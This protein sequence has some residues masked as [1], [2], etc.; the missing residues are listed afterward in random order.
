MQKLYLFVFAFF[1]MK[2]WHIIIFI[3][4]FFFSHF[5]SCSSSYMMLVWVEKKVI[6]RIK[7]ISF[8]IQNYFLNNREKVFFLKAHH[9]IRQRRIGTKHNI[10]YNKDDEVSETKWGKH[11]FLFLLFQRQCWMKKRD[12]LLDLLWKKYP[13][14]SKKTF[15]KLSLEFFFFFWVKEEMMKKLN[16]NWN[17]YMLSAFIQITIFHLKKEVLPS[18]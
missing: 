12:F 5:S 3:T 13:T 2:S 17:E 16:R 9:I 6:R 14:R 15:I 7:I 8:G 10:P 18:S 11:K 4:F 1:L